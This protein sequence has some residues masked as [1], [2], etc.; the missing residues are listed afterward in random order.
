[1]IVSL[2]NKVSLCFKE[3]L[4]N[5]K[6][7]KIYFSSLKSQKI[8]FSINLSFKIILIHMKIYMNAHYHGLK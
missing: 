6:I 8:K 7:N 5:I 1:M 3:E 4:Y 2:F